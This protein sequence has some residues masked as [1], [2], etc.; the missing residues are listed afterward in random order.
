MAQPGKHP[1]WPLIVVAL[2]VAGTLGLMVVGPLL[3]IFVSVFPLGQAHDDMPPAHIEALG[4]FRMPPNARNVRS[5]MESWLDMTMRVRF[6][7]PREDVDTFLAGTLCQEALTASEIPWQ[8]RLSPAEE[9]WR[10]MEAQRFR[11]GEGQEGTILQTYLIDETDPETAIVY[12]LVE[13]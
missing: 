2:V 3:L 4:K 13:D 12:V 9:W 8:D 10:P 6:E 1:L 11:A 7:I 5:H